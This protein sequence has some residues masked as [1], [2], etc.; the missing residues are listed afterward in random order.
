MIK[1][2]C[3]VDGYEDENSPVMKVSSHWNNDSFV[4]IDLEANQIIVSAK[5]L[6]AAIDN[7]TNMARH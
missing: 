6:K 5:D 1:V 3:Q 7:T 4:V 2:H